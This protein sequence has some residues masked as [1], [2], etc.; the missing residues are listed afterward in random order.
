MTYDY[1][2][3]L[4]AGASYLQPMDISMVNEA[5]AGL[6]DVRRQ[7][8]RFALPT[9]LL[10]DSYTLAVPEYADVTIRVIRK[11]NR[12]PVSPALLWFHGGGFVI[13]DAE[14]D[15]P[16]NAVVARDTGA[17]IVSVEYGLAPEHPYPT[18]IEQG[19]AALSWVHL[20]AE[21]LGIDNTRIAVGGQSAGAC[22]AAGLAI[23]ARDRG[24]PALVFQALDIPV[25]DNRTE[26][27]SMDAFDD[28]PGW[29]RSN[30]QDSWRA[31]L[32]QSFAGDVPPYAAP[33]RAADLTGL[34]PAYISAGEFDPLRDEAIAY[35]QRLV[36]SGVHTELH[37]FPGTFHGSASVAGE[38]EVSKSMSRNFIDSL[39][40]AFS[41]K[42]H[43][44]TDAA[45]RAAAVI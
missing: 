8:P 28:T 21:K 17:T 26:T 19:Y 6:A 2:A 31:Y 29:T 4:A 12:G 10:L 38:A 14:L 5:R 20:N 30:A 3:Q 34:P 44:P 18:A 11:R 43:N 24:G 41:S 39:N 25:T 42:L 13:G 1:D 15:Y 35:A 16:H 9:S 23:L 40:R 36:Q 45:V 32:G 37:L 27:P 22:L 7:M 33:N